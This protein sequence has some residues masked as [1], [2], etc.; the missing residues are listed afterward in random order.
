M[1]YGFK[2]CCNSNEYFIVEDIPAYVNVGETWYIQTTQGGFI[3]A[4]YVE[5]PPL[6]YSPQVF[7]WSSGVN[8]PSCD[9]LLDE[10]GIN[11]NNTAIVTS[12]EIGSGAVVTTNECGCRT[13][14]PMTVTC[15]SQS[16]TT[17]NGTNGVV[18]VN[19]QG[20]T[21][22]YTI[23]TIIGQ[24]SSPTT[25]ISQNPGVYTILN[26]AGENTYTITV[27]DYG[28]DFTQTV[29]CVLNT[30]PTPI[31]A[32][33]TTTNTTFY[34]SPTGSLTVTVNGG[35]P[36]Y[37]LNLVGTPTV[38]PITTAGSSR[39][40]S[41]LSANTYAVNIN[42]SGNPIVNERQT[43][44][45]TCTVIDA[46][47]LTFP[48]TICLSIPYCNQTYSLSFTKQSTLYNYR[49]IYLSTTHANIGVTNPMTL[50]Y[51]TTTNKWQTSAY[52]Q[53]GSWNVPTTC[54][55]AYSVQFSQ[56]TGNNQ[57]TGNYISQA[58]T[59]F[60][61]GNKNMSSGNCP[62]S[63]TLTS[64]AS[65]QLSQTP[66]GT[67]T[68]GNVQNGTPPYT[69]TIYQNST[70]INTQ[71]TP[72]FTNVASGTYKGVVTDNNGNTLTLAQ[73]P[74][75]TVAITQPSTVTW[76]SCYA[77]QPITITGNGTQSYKAILDGYFTG[78]PIGN[79]LTTQ[80]LTIY[81][82]ITNV[83]TEFITGINS[84]YAN[85]KI[86]K[87][88]IDITSSLSLSVETY[89]SGE[90]TNAMI[91]SKP[92]KQKTL[93]YTITMGN[94]ITLQNLEH[95]QIQ[96]TFQ[97]NS[98]NSITTNNVECIESVTY[99]INAETNGVNMNGPNTCYTYATSPYFQP[100]F[101]YIELKKTKNQTITQNSS[102]PNQWSINAYSY[103][104]TVCQNNLIIN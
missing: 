16:P 75:V 46:A 57:P 24:G 40:Y 53:T 5:I 81:I 63:Y 95:I 69:Y 14:I 61:T 3:A 67:I 52:T 28:A 91:C 80:N 29:I 96:V 4:T 101:D 6:N 71:L 51:E 56:Q 97:Y 9:L 62:L 30:P 54:T 58:G 104:G 44:S 82:A 43:T 19:I 86:F 85:L 50:R 2:N 33:C 98:T 49:P 92:R 60:S 26:N 65:C 12:L 94:Q 66:E 22:P 42:D 73:A 41:N 1:Q 64:T 39:T 102:T 78:I 25:Q 68:F 103:G 84:S 48:N 72:N 13:L 38:L 36:P 27:T 34:G 88:G 7:N 77:T 83:T 55:P 21:A 70:V 100:S 23:S 76:I 59:T 74:S 20:G 93:S 10:Y 45:V 90:S 31:N 15:Q 11:C 87:N 99:T 18:R 17:N 47:Q 8:F 89:D 37:F 35:T 79:S 32:T